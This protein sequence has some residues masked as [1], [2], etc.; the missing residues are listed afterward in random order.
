MNI[1]KLKNDISFNFLKTKKKFTCHSS[2]LFSYIITVQIVY[3][4]RNFKFILCLIHLNHGFFLCW[5]NKSTLKNSNKTI[6]NFVYSEINI[7]LLS[8][9]RSGDEYCARVAFVPELSLSSEVMLLES[10]KIFSLPVW[11]RLST[12]DHSIALFRNAIWFGLLS[13]FLALERFWLIS[14]SIKLTISEYFI[15]NEI[16]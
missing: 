1:S 4:V 14:R 12:V 7:F 6:L 3:I 9:W 16:N 15:R 2:W 10:I 8:E 5:V 11:F 13:M